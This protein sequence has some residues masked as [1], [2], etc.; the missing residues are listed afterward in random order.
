MASKVTNLELT[1][2]RMRDLLEAQDFDISTLLQSQHRLT[3]LLEQIDERHI[4]ATKDEFYQLDFMSGDLIA[5]S[6]AAEHQLTKLRSKCTYASIEKTFKKGIATIKE[7][8]EWR[9]K[10]FML[11]AAVAVLQQFVTAVSYQ[12]MMTSLIEA[13]KDSNKFENVCLQA[14]L[15]ELKSNKKF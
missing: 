10:H 5:L 3:N 12:A 4:K 1:I 15:S 11:A 9:N 2:C 14:I 6:E 8:H 13:E 7:F